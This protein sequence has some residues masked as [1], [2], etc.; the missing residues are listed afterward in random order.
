MPPPVVHSEHAVTLIG[1]GPVAPESLSLALERAPLLV[2]ADG[3]AEHA[4]ALGSL[5]ST[6]IGDLDSLINHKWWRKSGIAIY[7]FE[8]Q[9]STDFEKCISCIDAPL[10]VAVGFLEGRFDHALAVMSVLF[11]HRS[12]RILVLGREDVIFM[13]PDVLSLELEVGTR[14]SFFPLVKIRGLMSAG[15]RWPTDGLTLEP[16]A[17]IGTSNEAVSARVRA[18]FDRPG[19]LVILP[20]SCLDQAIKALGFNNSER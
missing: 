10:I 9:S 1:G 19:M 6:I 16:G 8:E 3:G 14:I 17:Q 12:Q 4:K 20:V 5:P 11:S 7:K 2:A 18:S 13:C 15:L